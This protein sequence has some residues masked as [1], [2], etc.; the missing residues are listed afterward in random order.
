MQTGFSSISLAHLSRRLTRWVYNIQMVRCPCVVVRR[1]RRHR[2]PSFQTWISL[3]TVGSS[4]LN[5][6]SCITW[7][8][9]KSHKALGQIW[10]KLLFPRQPIAPIDL[11]VFRR[12]APL[13]L[14]GL[15]PYLQVTGTAIKSRMSSILSQ[16]GPFTLELIALKRRKLFPYTYNGENL[17]VTRTIIKFR[18]SWN[19]GHIDYGIT[20]PW[21]WKNSI[22]YLFRSIPRLVLIGCL[23]DLQIIWTGI[24]SGIRKLI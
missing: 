3:W 1:H 10:S 22:F 23:L 5:F 4:W 6:T 8:G 2:S 9:G 18:T 17:Q 7:G 12:I 16:L 19:S 14:I 15:S 24:K 21:M 13:F 20:C 11:Y